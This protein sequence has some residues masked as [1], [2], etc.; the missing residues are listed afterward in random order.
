MRLD[1]KLFENV[2]NVGALGRRVLVRQVAH[3]K[4]DVGGDHLLQRGAKGGDQ[5]RRQIGN[6]PNR[7]GEH[8]ALSVG[9]THGAQRRVERGEQ[10]VLGQHFR[11]RQ[12][13]EQRGLSRVR[14]ADERDHRVRHVL[15]LLAMQA[16]RLLH[17][18]KLA[19]D[20][21]HALLNEAAVSLNL[22]FARTAKEAEAAA[23]AL[24]M[25]P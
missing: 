11:L 3:M 20:A 22:G 10:H 8:D 23:L 9:Q 18:L 13:V 24:Q 5:L 16:A 19:L 21:D 25:G 15:P 17:R 4:H 6:E 2:F 1:A 12:A 7:I 14:I